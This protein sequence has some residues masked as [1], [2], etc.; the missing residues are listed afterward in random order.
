MHYLCEIIMPPTDNIEQAVEQILKPYCE[1]NEGDESDDNA[2]WDWYVIGGRFAGQKLISGLD[3]EKLDLFYDE[4]KEL[5]V[6]VSSLQAGKQTLQPSDQIPMVDNLWK[7]HFPDFKGENCPL[8]SHSNDQY[9]EY[10]NG[11]VMKFNDVPDDLKCARVIFAAPAYGDEDGFR[12]GYMLS[13]SIWNGVNHQKTDFDG[14][15]SSA[16]KLFIESVKGY[17]KEYIEKIKPTNEWLVV[18]VDYHS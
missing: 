5:K 12:A 7:K 1:H 14:V 17:K 2:F 13:D 15:F 3:P 18:S 4:L 11:D 9:S 6:T 10:M 16:K 8:F